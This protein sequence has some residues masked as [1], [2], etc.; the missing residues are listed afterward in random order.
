MIPWHGRPCSAVVR[1]PP[2]GALWLAVGGERQLALLVVGGAVVN[3]AAN[4]VLIPRFGMSG[5]VS[6][7][8]SET[9]AR[10]RWRMSRTRNAS[11]STVPLNAI[12]GLAAAWAVK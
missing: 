1:V 3:V 11:S 7:A 5:A 9:T 8:G 12:F 10:T 4:V 2:L 6:A